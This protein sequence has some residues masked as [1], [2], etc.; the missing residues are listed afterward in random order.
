[1]QK[2]SQH[3]YFVAFHFQEDSVPA[4]RMK[5]FNFHLTFPARNFGTN[6]GLHPYPE[7]ASIFSNSIFCSVEMA[8]HRASEEGNVHNDDA[9]QLVSTYLPRPTYP[10][11]GR[12]Q[13]TWDTKLEMFSRYK[14][15]GNW[16][17]VARNAA[18]WDSLL[19]C[20]L[21]FCSM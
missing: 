14:A 8:A 6:W 21:D 12:P 19:P 1:M 11:C 10:S 15:F 4:L 20:F 3:K 5:W 18:R 9:S 13:Q 2:S 7:L 17:I 16:E